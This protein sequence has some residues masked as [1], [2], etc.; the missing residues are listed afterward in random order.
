MARPLLSSGHHGRKKTSSITVNIGARGLS[1][2]VYPSA[3]IRLNQTGTVILS[4]QV[5]ENGRVGEVRIEQSSGYA[6]L[7]ESAMREAR[8]WRFKPGSH[9]H[10][11]SDVEADPDH[12]PVAELILKSD[13]SPPPVHTVWTGGG[14]GRGH[15]SPAKASTD[16]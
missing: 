11:D 16:K 5:L 3:A 13:S 8:L 4:V 6:R 1:E 10:S 2:A 9:G 7:D 12:V 14:S 15:L